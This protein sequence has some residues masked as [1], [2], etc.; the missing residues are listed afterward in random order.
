V[1]KFWSQKKSLKSK[2]LTTQP[3]EKQV[4]LYEL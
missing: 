1:A 3:I 4:K 2:C